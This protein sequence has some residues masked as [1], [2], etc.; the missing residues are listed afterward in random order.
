MVEWSRSSFFS[1]GRA[2]ADAQGTCLELLGKP[3][4][5]PGSVR[6]TG[7]V[8]FPFLFKQVASGTPK[9]HENSSKAGGGKWLDAR[10]V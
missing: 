3:G 7:G 8:S 4:G 6:G 1:S 2:L 9:V 10:L 5:S